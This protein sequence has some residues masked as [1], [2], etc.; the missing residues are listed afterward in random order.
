MIVKFQWLQDALVLCI[1]RGYGGLF[2]VAIEVE[3]CA[4]RVCKLHL[5]SPDY[6][7]C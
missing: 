1:S 7:S 2:Q 4:H 3:D 5:C 6:S